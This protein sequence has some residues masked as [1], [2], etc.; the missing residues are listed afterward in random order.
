ML[1][2]QVLAQPSLESRKSTPQ[3]LNGVASTVHNFHPMLDWKKG[4]CLSASATH[5]L[6]NGNL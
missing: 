3:H 5:H 1:D 2:A 4:A 6:R